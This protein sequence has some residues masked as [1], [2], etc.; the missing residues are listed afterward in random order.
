MCQQSRSIRDFDHHATCRIGQFEVFNLF[1]LHLHLCLAVLIILIVY[2]LLCT[3]TVDTYYRHCSSANYIGNVSVP[4][5]CISALDDPVCT[6]EAIP[7]DECRF[8]RLLL[9]SS[10]G[11]LENFILYLVFD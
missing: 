8:L 1:S 9:F 10:F 4:L 11:H 6:K 3:Q 2:F 7:W 5:L